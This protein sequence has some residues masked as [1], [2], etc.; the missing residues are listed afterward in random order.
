MSSLPKRIMEHA[1]ALPE[2][3]PL[4]SGAL[5]HMGSRAAVNRALSRL[6]ASKRLL[7]IC[8]GVYMRP[9]MTQFGPRPPFVQEAIE[10][11]SKLW[12]ETVVP[13]GASAANVLGLTTQ[14]PVRAVY[15][16]SGP[17]CSLYFKRQQVRLRHVPEWLLAAPYRPAGTAVR[18][19]AWLGPREVEEA[20]AKIAPQLSSDDKAELAAACA[21]IPAWMAKPVSEIIA[22]GR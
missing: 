2:A 6:A 18:A 16:T 9:V 14:N 21:A 10:S 11:L 3:T 17:D 12:D 13:C 20:L 7:R 1:E 19:L 22:R 5:L 4:H 8:R 15:F